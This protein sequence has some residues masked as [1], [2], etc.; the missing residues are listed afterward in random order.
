MSKVETLLQEIKQLPQGDLELLMIAIQQKLE[1]VKRV[2]SALSK[3][4]GAGQG[5]WPIDAQ[6]Y[7]NQ[8]RE[9]R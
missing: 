5:V 3:V 1:R 8:S 9:D 4:R 7:V 6:E 2:K